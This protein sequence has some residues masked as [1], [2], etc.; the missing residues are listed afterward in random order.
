MK[1]TKNSRRFAREITGVIEKV[2]APLSGDEREQRISAVERTI[3]R[4]SKTH[5]TSS[6]PTHTPGY[7]V[8]ARHRG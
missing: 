4:A 6:A 8:A 3:Y 7:R 5:S 2:F 1:K